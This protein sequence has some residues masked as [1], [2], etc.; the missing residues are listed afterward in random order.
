MHKSRELGMQ[1]FD[2][3]LINLYKSGKISLDEALKNADSA[4]NVRLQIKLDSNKVGD[5]DAATSLQLDPIMDD[6]VEE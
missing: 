4:N 3:A 2:Q 5:S 1:T 6:G